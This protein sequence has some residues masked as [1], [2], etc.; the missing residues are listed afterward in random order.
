MSQLQS[1]R[2]PSLGGRAPTTSARSVSSERRRYDETLAMYAISGTARAME[3]DGERRVWTAES[4]G[5]LIVRAPPRGEVI[6]E[7]KSREASFCTA[8]RC[9][10]AKRM[11]AAFSDG[12]IYCYNTSNGAME[13]EFVRHDGAVLCMASSK[14]GEYVYSGGEDWKVYQWSKSS[15]T[16]VRLFSGHTNAVR[17]VLVVTAPSDTSTTSPEE[18]S[19]QQ[20]EDEDDEKEIEFPDADEATVD[21]YVLSGSDDSTIRVWN[22]RAPLQ[23]EKNVACIAT[24]R[25]HQKSIRAMEIYPRTKELW[26]GSDDC[27]VRVWEWRNKDERRC[28][29]VLDGQHTAPITAIVHVAPR[30]W[31]SG[32]DGNVVVWDARDH[33]AVRRF[34][35]G[36][37]PIFSMLR[38][39]R[40]THWTVWVGGPDGVIHAVHAVGEENDVDVKLQRYERRRARSKNKFDRLQE[41]AWNQQQQMEKLEKRNKILEENLELLNEQL[42]KERG[43]ENRMIPEKIHKTA[44]DNRLAEINNLKVTIASLEAQRN[45]SENALGKATITI[46]EKDNII[47]TLN[48][49]LSEKEH[50]IQQMENQLD[51]L[52]AR[53]GSVKTENETELAYKELLL[54]EA[55]GTIAR[56]STAFDAYKEKVE[57]QHAKEKMERDLLQRKLLEAENY[58]ELYEA[59]DDALREALEQIDELQRN[60]EGEQL[61]VNELLQ[62]LTQNTQKQ[63]SPSRERKSSESRSQPIAPTNQR[64]NKNNFYKRLPGTQWTN[65]CNTHPE[66]LQ[67]TLIAEIT[68][69]I[70]STTAVVREVTYASSYNCLL[71][72]VAL[73]H[74]QT[75][76]KHLHDVINSY[77]FPQT[78]TLHNSLP[79]TS[80][81]RPNWSEE[82][83]SQQLNSLQD[84]KKKIES[85]RDD[86]LQQLQATAKELEGHRDAQR[87]AEEQRARIAPLSEQSKSPQQRPGSAP[88][89]SGSKSQDPA[90]APLYS[91]TAQEYENVV[92]DKKKA[93]E[94][95]HDALQQLQATA[96]ELEGHRDA[97]RKAEEQRARIA[98]LSEQSKSS[99]SQDPAPA[100]LYS[101]TAQEY[102]N[103]VADKK[104]AEEQLHDALQQ[105]QATAKELEGHRDAQRK[106]EEQRARIAPL[107]EQSK[108]PQQRPGSAPPRS[109][110]KSQDPA[111]APLY[112]ITAQEYENV[113]AD[114]KKAEEQLHDALQQLQATAKEL[115]G[116]RDAQRKA[117]EQRARIAPLSEQSKSPQQ[118]PGSAPPRSGSKSQDPAPAPL[119]SITAQEYENVVA[120]KKKAEEQLHDALQQLQATAKELEG[121]RDAQRKAEEQ[122]ARI[123]PLSEQSKSPQQR[124][125]S[126]PPRS[127]SKSQDPA[128][129]PLYSITAQEYENVVADKKKAEEQL[130]DALQQLQ[131]TAKELEGHRDAQR[132]AE[133][134][135][136]R[137]APLSEQS[138]SP[139]QRPGSAPPRSGSK[140]QDPAPAPP[141]SITAQEYENVVADKKKA[142]AERDDALQQLQATAKEL[143]GHR[144]AQRKAEEQ[145]ARIAPLS[146][147]SKSP[148]QRP[149]S[150]PPRSGSKSQDPAPA[151]L[152]SIT[153]Q[154]Y[155]NVVADKKKAEEQLHDALQQLQATAK[156]LE[157][158]RD[159]QRKAEEQRAR[160]APLSEQSKSPQ[161]RPG[162]APPRS[163]SKSQDPAPAPLY[164]ITAQEYEN[165]VADKK[166]AEA[167]RDDALQQLQ[168]TAKE[169]EGHRDA[170]RKAEE[171]RARIAPLSEQSKSPQQRPGSAPPRS[172]S[173]SQDPAPAPLYSITAQ[174]YEN[175]VA[176][177][178]KAEEQLHDA[179]QQLQATAKE[180]EGHRDAQ[181]KAEEQ[182][183]RIAPLSEQ[184]KSPQQRPGS[185]PPRSGSKSQDPAPAPLYSITAQEYENVVADKK[186]AEA[187]RN[188]ALQ[189]LQATAKELEGHRDAQRKA[190]EQR[191]RIAPLSEQS[192]SPQ[193]RPGSAPPRSGSKSQDPAPAPLY[194]ITAQEYENVVADKKK[195]E[196][197]LHDALQQL[198]ATAKELEGHRDAQRKA[199]EQRARIAPLSEQSKSPQ[200]RP[201]SAPPRSGSKSQDPAPAPLY[202]ITAQEY[203]N[204]VADKK[205][206]EEQLHDALQQLQAT[207]KELEGHRD[208]QRK[209]EEQR[210]RIAPLSEQSKSPQQRPGSAPP[211]S[212]SKSQDPAPA[213]L[214]SITAQE[215]ENVVA[216]KKKAE[217][218]RDDALQQLQATAKELEGHR[219]AQRK[220]EEQ[221][222]RI[223]PLSEQSKSPQQRPGSAPPRSGSKSQDPAPAPLYSITAQEYENVVADKK[224]AEAERDDALQQL[225]A[226]AKELEGHRDA[227]RKAEEQR[228]RIAPLSEQSKSP[229]QRPGSAPP[230][231]GSKSQDPAPAPLY[232]ITAQEYEN[233]VADKK[234][235]E[236]ERDDAL[237]QL[238]ATAK[239][240]EG[241]RDAQRKA[242]EQRARIAPLSEQSKSPQQRPGSAPPRSGSK[243]QDPAPAPLYSITAQEYENVVA[244]KK[245]AEEQLHDA[246]Q[247]LQ[248]TVKELEGHRDAQRKA[249]EQRARIAPLSEQSK[250]PQQRP[251]SA[252]PRSGSK[253]QDPA[254][255][256]LYS[257]TA[258]EYENVV[259]DKKKAEAE[260]DDALQRLQACANVPDPLN[261]RELVPYLDSMS[262]TS[263][264]G[265]E[266]QLVRK[267]DSSESEALVPLC[268]VNA[269]FESFM[270]AKRISEA[271]RDDAPHRLCEGGRSF[272]LDSPLVSWTRHRCGLG[273]NWG[274]LVSQYRQLVED[275]FVM[276]VCRAT[277]VPSDCVKVVNFVSG[278]ALVDLEVCHSLSA[279]DID[280][281]LQGH[282][283]SG[284]LALLRLSGSSVSPT[285]SA[286]GGEV[287]LV[288]QQL[289]EMNE[290]LQ[291]QLLVAQAELATYRRDQPRRN[292]GTKIE[293][294]LFKELMTFRNRRA[295]ANSF[296]G[297]EE[298]LEPSFSLREAIDPKLPVDPAVLRCEPIYSVTLDE[299]RDVLQQLRSLCSAGVEDEDGGTRLWNEHVVARVEEERRFTH[300][301]SQLNP[302]F[303]RCRDGDL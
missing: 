180:L 23:I 106:A 230:R 155:E 99:K 108:S 38:L 5:R 151:P 146:E 47:T 235:A 91:I 298:S 103:V 218:E 234:K 164:S 190:E 128:P 175:V 166:K 68:E 173:K 26:S 302:K 14:K 296:R 119:Y 154:E 15:C 144:D 176:D 70:A 76:E 232:S 274:P 112:S 147:Q 93:E 81:T 268:N 165:V 10:S 183:A 65:V 57:K 95:L 4:D 161:Q 78:I 283:F 33:V 123:A 217:A 264:M 11:W 287:S 89:R 84:E 288:S 172:G 37:R 236:A 188:D 149:G 21:E 71:L 67:E 153:A 17:C 44:M 45:A 171:Q 241:H 152:Y 129:A 260:R 251:G 63:I 295:L 6:F 138:K 27:T 52:L 262:I 248:A 294:A 150:A 198:Q 131:A 238:Q 245:K 271:K 168:A 273:D 31:S 58:K 75:E 148:Q 206:A 101:I 243:S 145:R 186:K 184:S 54:Q 114:K 278:G 252:P 213:P 231:S 18:K 256:P 121:H 229:Q 61:Y 156:E 100:P 277:A 19:L 127:G 266:G 88:P 28:V 64:S 59:K 247:Q 275:V 85:E 297:L 48:H 69:I 196:E 49:Q 110:S 174:E 50:A 282:M 46:R 109:G 253:S 40:S 221:R 136:A 72:E 233:V 143:E 189:Q 250:S 13:N 132:K 117:E 98:P 90:P 284:M 200:Q 226:T 16:Y 181:R 211:R 293:N 239:E 193:Q 113:V 8:L 74:N 281:L 80:S 126:A 116:H 3:Y 289:M 2:S 224:K 97:Q 36:V 194:S 254:P 135:R 42:E 24:L 185:A 62:E 291:K 170:Q 242:E 158:H 201:G 102:E 137:I 191:A 12:F 199:E 276:E 177:K 77:T 227:Q 107:S 140:S 55:R 167:E 192:K 269:P 86:A 157:G 60:L 187:E 66:V 141:Y 263:Y 265:Q 223:A 82:H 212:G 261:R 51:V 228:A 1:Q 214:Y 111:P 216:D 195:A 83:L 96:K 303:P 208:A 244:D 285:Q 301:L 9:V 124:P 87:K 56:N 139:Q 105:L 267:P 39:Y 122:R 73:E 92:A 300:Q 292:N 53:Q 134:Q 34:Q 169:L 79:K 286:S 41:K 280:T 203:E 220:A 22:P 43:V 142:E 120:D 222:A 133:E 240:L 259:A 32:K 205:K 290:Q 246:L 94:Q 215:Y 299:Y 30:M 257:I 115:E 279:E 25:G 20:I 179:L 125:G 225:Q 270:M 104:K 204:V 160:I 118:R 258:Q 29:A 207:A 209:A 219:D 130:H 162:S 178:K 182:R 255:A 249:E 210:A 272:G 202:S 7:A 159:A 163:G 197:Q 237:Q 35:P